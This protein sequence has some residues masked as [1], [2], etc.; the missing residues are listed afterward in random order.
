MFEFKITQCVKKL[1][2]TKL[3]KQ[4]SLK[5]DRELL[6]TTVLY[7]ICTISLSIYA[8]CLSIRSLLSEEEAIME[9]RQQ[10]GVP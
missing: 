10:I 4:N 2:F 3:N 1:Y 8:I 9:L 6:S 5:T 7:D